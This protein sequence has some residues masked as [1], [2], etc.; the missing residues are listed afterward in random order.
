[1]K[2]KIIILTSKAKRHQY[3]VHTL[4]EA[5]EVVGVIQEAKKPQAAGA[6]SAE[7]AV[8]TKHF[9]ERDEAEERYFGA[10]GALRVADSLVIENGGINSQEVFEWIQSRSPDYIVLFG[11]G[12]VKDPILSAFD[13]RVVNIH[14][15]LSPYYRG[16]GTNF[17][18]LVDGLPECVG[19][20]IHLATLAVDGGPI[21]LQVRPSVEPTDKNHDVGCK[22]IIA[23]AAGMVRALEAYQKGK[24]TLH[25][26]PVGVGKVYKKAHFNADAVLTMWRNFEQGMMPAYVAK[27]AERDAKYPIVES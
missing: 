25:Q 7:D 27:R 24:I 13:G 18:P 22:T 9:A 10:H 26:Q 16:S 3:F 5:F 17:W 8:I 20:T 19:A 14:L 4:A 1:M 12:I 23:G 6:T 11:T 2:P 15:G 21:L